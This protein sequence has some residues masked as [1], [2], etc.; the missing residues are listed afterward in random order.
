MTYVVGFLLAVPTANKDDYL[1]FSEKM[2]GI[3]KKHG[4]LSVYES[5]ANDVPDGKLNSMHTAVMRKP[6]ETVVFSWVTWPAK[7]AR[8]KVHKK[9]VEA[10]HTEMENEPIPFDVSRMIYGGFYVILDRWS[11]CKY[12]E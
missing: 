1:A 2:A 12:R 4:A 7:E 8:D 10:M 11:D 6:N 9:I 3:Y 5:W